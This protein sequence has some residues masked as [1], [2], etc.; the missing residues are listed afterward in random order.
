MQ[1]YS[2]LPMPPGVIMPYAGVSL[3]GGYLWCDG[4]SYSRST[5]SALD[6]VLN[7]SKGTV[8]MT[9]ASPCVVSFTSHG[10]VEGDQIFFTTTGSLPTGITAYTEYFVKSPAANT[11][12]ISTTR[13]STAAGTAVNT[14]GSQSGTHTLWRTPYG[15]ASSTNFYTPDLRGRVPHA[16]DT[17]GGT[18]A[19][20]LG[21]IDAIGYGGG[22]ETHLLTS[23]ES[24][25][26]AHNHPPA[27]GTN[28]SNYGAGLAYN[29]SSSAT[30]NIG[31]Y[32]TKTTTGSNT[33][34]DAA[35]AHNTMQP[36]L[37]VPYIIKY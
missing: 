23:G 30:L 10:L 37:Y 25:L 33:A 9:I 12:N 1:T 29:G 36:F 24:G 35:S 19:S 5:Y 26:P 18:A 32:D 4:G 17:L 8:T 20:R 16:I 11:F 14:S 27:S 6:A 31:P 22:E 28:F 21:T 3:P 2:S 15:L 7:P 34:A 13:T